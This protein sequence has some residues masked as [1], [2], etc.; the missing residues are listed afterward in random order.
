M[1]GRISSSFLIVT[2]WFAVCTPGQADIVLEKERKL[3]LEAEKQLNARQYRKFAQLIRQLEDYPL[4]HWLEYRE[5]RK[6]LSVSKSEAIESYLSRFSDTPYAGR[7]R[8]AW[9][10]H[11]AK[12]GDWERFLKNYQPQRSIALQCHYHWAL[13]QSGE[14]EKALAGGRDL[15]LH[16]KSRPSACDKLFQK[17]QASRYLTP[18][19]VWSRVEMAMAAGNSQ[20]ANYLK[21]FLPENEKKIVSFW[22]KVHR[23]PYQ[24]TNCPNWDQT[25][26]WGAKIFIHGVLRLARKNSELALKVWREHSGRFTMGP[27]LRLPVENKFALKFALNRNPLAGEQFARIPDNKMTASV[28][29]WR[30]R[31]ALGKNDWLAANDAIESLPENEKMLPKW[32]YWSARTLASQGKENESEAQYA[33]LAA[34]RDYY[35]FLAPL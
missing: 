13:Y 16:G 18:A 6:R 29:E 11:L 14:H 12:N 34:S 15:W 1:F 9:L 32:R 10:K 3:F 22:T 30:I 7:L 33:E 26:R 2:L 4:Y 35:G 19:L 25:G 24:L 8:S 28:R 27:A 17:L 23:D 5:L 31:H 21:R 20:L